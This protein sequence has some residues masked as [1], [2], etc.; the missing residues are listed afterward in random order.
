LRT[1]FDADRA[2]ALEEDAPHED[3]AVDGQVRPAGDGVQ[4]RIGG[5]A[6][7]AVPLRQL[8]PADALL[9]LAVQS[10]LRS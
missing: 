10:G 2:V 5:A 4:E 7:Q 6:A 9:V 8:E 1:K 3:A